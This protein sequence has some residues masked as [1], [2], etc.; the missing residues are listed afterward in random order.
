MEQFRRG[1]LV[2]DVR[3]CGPTDAPV[4]VLLHGHPQTN[5]AWDAIVP[6]LAEA[7]YRC[8]AP[9]QRGYSRGA[10]P[11][12]RRDY[13]MSE[14]VDDVGALVDASGAESVHLVGH[15]FGGLVA[16]SFASKNPQRVVTLSSL[17]SPHPTALQ[18]AMMTSSQGLLSWYAYAYQVP[19]IP[20]WFYLGIDRSGAR[21]ARMLRSGGQRSELAD[22]DA[23][24]MTAPGAYS[25]AL[26]WYRAAPWSGRTGEVSVPTLL[27]W[28]DGDKYIR[29]R[30]ARRSSCY[31]TGDFRF[32][33]L[34]GSHWL[35]DEQ[36]D[37]VVDLLLGWFARYS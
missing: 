31:V 12:R 37:A 1:D 13:R 24:E 35:P 21:L 11:S 3:D 34:R 23:R 29:E 8:L 20:E 25:A 6:Q 28:S 22:R 17:S 14:L 18:R 5:V 26:H 32:E 10:R 9:N 27:M 36:P 19:R 2:F 16:W 7:G 33:I 15:D 4:V 30:A